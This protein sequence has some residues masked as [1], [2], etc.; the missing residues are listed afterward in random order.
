MSKNTSPTPYRLTDYL[1]IGI[2]FLLYGLVKY[3]PSPIGDRF[4]YAIAKPFV[5][6]MG[7]VRLYE[8]VTLWYPYKI[9]IGHNVTLNEWVYIDGFGGVE[10]GDSARIAHRATIL[11][12]DHCHEDTTRP[13]Y[14]QGIRVAKTII[15][16]DVWIGANA[17]IM[18]GVRIGR[19]AIIAAGAVVTKDVPVFAIVAGVP[20]K[21]ISSRGQ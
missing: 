6:K 3:F 16:D 10:I 20:A 2:F 14:Q 18:P 12:S 15:G 19:G 5:G 8:G 7:K 17:V 1:V 9:F 21:I 13:I 4:R 11:S